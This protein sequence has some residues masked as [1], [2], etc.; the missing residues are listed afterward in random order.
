MSRFILLLIIP[1]LLVA[2]K[3]DYLHKFNLS[4]DDVAIIK[5][6]DRKDKSVQD[7]RFRWTL[8]TNEGLILL[9]KYDGFPTQY[10]LE[11]KYKQNSIKIELRDDYKDS[12]NRSYLLLRFKDFKSNK[13][14]IEA[15]VSDQTKSVD[16]EFIDPNR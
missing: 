13:A 16:I 6:I 10:T 1:L 3:W 4:K 11:K 2:F 9:V 12:L 15:V 14:V 7:L 5:V 8:F